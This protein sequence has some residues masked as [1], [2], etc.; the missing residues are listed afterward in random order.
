VGFRECDPHGGRKFE[1]SA[2]EFNERE[3]MFTRTEETAGTWLQGSVLTTADK[4]TRVFGKP[5]KYEKGGKVNFEWGIVFEDGTI[6]TI[7]DW[8]QE[9]VPEFFAETVFHIGG[10]VPQAVDLVL[11]ALEP[12]ILRSLFIEGREWFDKINGNSYFSAR[13]WVDG[14][15]IAIL[16]FQYGYGSQFEYEAQKKLLELGYIPQEEK[17]AG[18][19][20]IAQKL[21]FD[22]YSSKSETKKSE[23]FKIY[24]N[25]QEQ[26]AV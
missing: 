11:K 2:L 25:Y 10:F 15:Q 23:M 16:P 14:G 8:K 6:A 7:Y 1:G 24:D 3:K 12:K 17:N 21:G 22:F 4:L 26:K 19:W 20:S 9:T 13:I 18:L 5:V